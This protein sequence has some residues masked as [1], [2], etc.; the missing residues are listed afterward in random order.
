MTPVATRYTRLTLTTLLAVGVFLFWYVG[1]P[2]ALNFQEQFQLFLWTDDYFWQ[3]LGTPGGLA[4]WLGEF[5]VQFYYIKWLGALLLALL[6]AAL[7]RASWLVLHA[8]LG[9]SRMSNT[10][11]YGLSFAL[12]LAL[13]WLMGDENVLA[14]LPIAML[15]TLIAVALMQRLHRWWWLLIVPLLY[16]SI[17]M[18]WSTYYRIPSTWPR[19]DGYERDRYELIWQDYATRSEKW[20]DVLARA[21]NCEVR[22]AFWSNC[23]NLALAQKRQLADRQFDFYQSGPNAL[24]MEPHR[25][26][27]SN[28]PTAEAYWRLGFVNEAERYMTEIQEA[29]LNGKKSVRCTRRIAECHIV[30]GQYALA[31][32]LLRQLSH[33]LFYSQW[34][35]ETLKLISDEA[36]V[37]AHP[38]YGHL[39]QLRLQDEQ[40]FSYSHIEQMLGQ[41]ITI[42][43]SNLM[44]LDYFMGQLLLTG[45]LEGFQ[46]YL[47]WVEQHGGYRRMP[48]GYQD[49]MYSLQHNEASDSPY[50]QYIRQQQ[51]EIATHEKNH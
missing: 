26:M 31:A 43:P 28:L 29:T 25:D 13:L 24:L 21:S 22:T 44:A 39:R 48:L 12:P 15:L 35:E 41:L 11:G 34:A 7:Q 50:L 5:L 16:W 6:F 32:K 49:V 37:K 18:Q 9:K 46:H 47:G 8:L 40:L 42:N 2:Q 17:G 36:A 27:M 1:Y 45:N 14:S 38:L 3:R 19:L 4:D 33:T 23:V 30:N 10:I 20:D 51:K